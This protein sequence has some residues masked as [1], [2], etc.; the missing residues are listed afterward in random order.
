MMFDGPKCTDITDCDPARACAHARSRAYAHAHMHAF[1]TQTE[2]PP[3]T[4]CKGMRCGDGS[5]A[6]V[7]MVCGKC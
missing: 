7:K 3:V 1:H 2:N 5:C 6:A 4:E